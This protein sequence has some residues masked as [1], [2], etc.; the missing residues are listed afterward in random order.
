MKKAAI[1]ISVF[2]FLLAASCRPPTV[3]IY[4][5]MVHEDL[6]VWEEITHSIF[7]YQKEDTLQYLFDGYAYLNADYPVE[8]HSPYI[9]LYT[10]RAVRCSG[11][12]CRCIYYPAS[13]GKKHSAA[14]GNAG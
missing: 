13:Y 4:D 6:S 14:I 12:T 9:M 11:G 8:I 2:L 10:Q 1:I 5:G 3:L 7:R